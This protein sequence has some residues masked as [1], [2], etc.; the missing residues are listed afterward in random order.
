[1]VLCRKKYSRTTQISKK[2]CLND[3]Y[4]MQQQMTNDITSSM[5]NVITIIAKTMNSIKAKSNKKLS[6]IGLD[7]TICK[8]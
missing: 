3:V 5:I 8:L 6:N 4:F 2:E 1:M 7:T